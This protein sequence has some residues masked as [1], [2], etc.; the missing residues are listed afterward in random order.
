MSTLDLVKKAY[1]AWEKKDIEALKPLL[2]KDYKATMPGG[3]EIVGIEGAQK[4]LE[5]CPFDGHSENETYIVDGNRVVRIW[6]FVAT[7]PVQFRARMAELNIVEDGKVIF[8][9]AFF[10]SAAFPKEAK[11]VADAAKAKAEDKQPATA[12]GTNKK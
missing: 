2:H 12:G 6:D 11:D 4:C 10:D 5:F 8:N 9:E 3:M 1:A 7:S